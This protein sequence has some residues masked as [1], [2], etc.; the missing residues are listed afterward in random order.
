M[1]PGHDAPAQVWIDR[2]LAAASERGKGVDL[3]KLAF[4]EAQAK[5]FV[6][7]T[8]EGAQALDREARRQ[9]PRP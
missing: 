7:L 3:S 9:K 4:R 5:A 1:I 2:G 6:H 8:G